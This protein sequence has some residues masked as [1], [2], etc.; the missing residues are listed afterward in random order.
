MIPNEYL[1]GAHQECEAWSRFY[2]LWEAASRHVDAL[3]ASG[4]TDEQMVALKGLRES[5]DE[6]EAYRVA[7]SPLMGFDREN[8]D[9]DSK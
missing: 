2:Q 3:I 9:D 4:A 1:D 7:N 5:L 8:Q 6:A